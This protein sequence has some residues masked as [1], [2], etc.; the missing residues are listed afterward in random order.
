MLSNFLQLTQRPGV[1][2]GRRYKNVNQ[3]SRQNE[4]LSLEVSHQG[5]WALLSVA[6]PSPLSNQ[7]KH[8]LPFFSLSPGSCLSFLKGFTRRN[9]NLFQYSCLENPTEPGGF[10]S[11]AERLTLSPEEKVLRDETSSTDNCEHT[12]ISTEFYLF[13]VYLS[14]SLYSV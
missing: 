5:P 4:C 6:F 8:L 14:C 9:G 10:R 7:S 3:K 13:P 2:E 11:T 12:S 1:L